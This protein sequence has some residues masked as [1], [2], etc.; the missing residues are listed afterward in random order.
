M[1]VSSVN[2]FSCRRRT[3]A[4]G[5]SVSDTSM[6]WPANFFQ[7]KPPVCAVAVFMIAGAANTP[8]APAP[9]L[10]AVRRVTLIFLS[11][12]FFSSR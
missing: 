6:L 12:I 10:S 7:L 2:S 11:S 5:P 4:R 9:I 8:A 1:P 3:S